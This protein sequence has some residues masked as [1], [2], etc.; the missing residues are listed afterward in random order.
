MQLYTSWKVVFVASFKCVTISTNVEK[1]TGYS[2]MDFID[3]KL[4]W[5]DIVFPEDVTII[6][7]AVKKAR[8]SKS[9]YQIEYR[10]KKFNGSM[11]FI[12]EKAHPVCDDTGKLAYI[13]GVFLDMTSEVNRKGDSHNSVKEDKGIQLE[14]LQSFVK[15]LSR[16]EIP[17]PITD[18]YNG[19]FNE[20]KKDVNNC[21]EGLQGLVECNNVL[22]HMALNDHTKGVEGKYVGIYESMAESTNEVRDRLLKVTKQLNDIAVGD[23]SQL[24]ELKRVG[25]R[26]EQDHLLPAV[27]EVMENINLL[28]EDA[29]MLSRAAVEGKLDTRADVSKHH[30]EY[31]KIVE[32]VNDTLD[33][34]IGPFN[35]AAEYVERISRGDIPKPI[36]DNYNGDF[37][38]IKNNLK[39]CITAVNYLVEDALLLSGAAV[40]GKLDTRANAAKHEGDFRKIVSGV[41]DTLDAVIGPLNVAAEYVERI[42]RDSNS[43]FE[44]KHIQ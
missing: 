22:H 33:A 1:L 42:S 18:N 23:T 3:K 14:M 21:I 39:K 28:I 11:A 31:R 8:K 37:N 29:G 38:E 2:K 19:D 4:S 41:N 12:Q 15:S 44:Q 9:S 10:I 36:T 25:K 35:V 30:G 27:I 26:S 13:V 5:S 43:R 40:A 16:G 34:V 32:G 24:M 7:K 6:D 20:I 17:E